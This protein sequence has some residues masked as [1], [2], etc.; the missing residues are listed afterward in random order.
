VSTLN[1]YRAA[2]VGKH[3]E[4]KSYWRRTGVRR[5]YIIARVVL[6]LAAELQGRS[7]RLAGVFVEDRE[8]V[9]LFATVLEVV[10][11]VYVDREATD[12][13]K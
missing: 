9:I 5:A 8:N 3:C 12:T 4:K 2:D 7:H 6:V 10:R 11:E 13:E 1:L